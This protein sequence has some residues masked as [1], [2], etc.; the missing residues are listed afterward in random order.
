MMT[1]KQARAER[2]LTIRGLAEKAG[3]AFST[4]YLVENGRSM[5]RFEVIRKLSD[6]LGVEPRQIAEFRA[7]ME[8]VS[9]GKVVAVAA[10]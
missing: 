10:T 3:V 5:P 6:A 2:L 1:L 9:T 7:A 8:A 4:V